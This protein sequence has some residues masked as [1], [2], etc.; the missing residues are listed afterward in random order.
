VTYIIIF[1]PSVGEGSEKV[2]SVTIIDG[3]SGFWAQVKK[4]SATVMRMRPMSVAIQR[5]RPVPILIEVL[6]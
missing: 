5:Y 3:G 6:V 1:E 2:I 4:E